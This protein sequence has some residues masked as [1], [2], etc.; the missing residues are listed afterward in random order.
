[1][2]PYGFPTA[3]QD[4][5]SN[6]RYGVTV[7]YCFLWIFVASWGLPSRSF[8]A[9]PAGRAEALYLQGRYPEALRIYERLGRRRSGGL[10]ALLDAGALSEEMGRPAAAAGF[11]ERAAAI[12]LSTDVLDAAG[13][14]WYRAGKPGRARPYFEESLHATERD[15]LAY[16]GMGRIC[17]GE[18][19]FRAANGFFKEAARIKPRWALI[20]Y[21]LGEANERLGRFRR[22]IGYFAKA[23]AADAYFLEAREALARAYLRS[24]SGLSGA[25]Q[26]RELLRLEPGSKTR[27]AFEK[28]RIGVLLS[29]LV[30]APSGFS[31]VPAFVRNAI[32]RA[33]SPQE[34]TLLRIG[35][36]AD[37][38]GRPALLRYAEASATT[39]YDVRRRQDGPALA[40]G[41]EREPCQIALRRIGRRTFLVARIGPGPNVWSG[42]PLYIKPRN[43]GLLYW[44]SGHSRAAAARGLYPGTIEIRVVPR[45]GRFEFIDVVDLANY[46]AAVTASEMPID[47]PMEA[48]KAQAILAR[49]YALFLKGRSRRHAAAGFDLC[50]SPHCQVYGGFRPWI[51]RASRAAASTR[52]LVVLRGK[53]AAPVVYSADCGGMTEGGG[54]VPGWNRSLTWPSVV[55]A[56]AASWRPDSPWKLKRWLETWPDAYCGPA[57]GIAPSHFRW[58]RVLSRRSLENILDEKFRL[59]R[60]RRILVLRRSRSGRVQE[61]LLAGSRRRRV[62][63][64]EMQ[65]RALG[66]ADRLRSSLFRVEPEYGRG[67]N[68]KSFVVT[69]AGWGHGAGVCQS[70]AIGRAMAGEDFRGILKDYLGK[71]VIGRL[72]N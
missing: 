45:A 35:L 36:G 10:A 19:R 26:L 24:G 69:G 39:A 29:S 52:G 57:Y 30:R 64:D 9:A 62:L 1:M 72:R 17:L 46:V 14:A 15:V 37:S 58:V 16:V 65:I 70:G 12:S 38:R 18:G 34:G 67:G 41:G 56:E 22:A 54:D 8:A 3:G 31:R 33:R 61:L 55:D 32:V 42:G 51:F 40:V 68:V 60:L 7:F 53:S 28:A 49:S 23:V 44:S 25:L 59:G 5:P 66:G 6:N 11:Y 2:T 13:W 4:R 21:D 63:R 27:E 43:N 50:D 48:L 71:I 20:F 47:A